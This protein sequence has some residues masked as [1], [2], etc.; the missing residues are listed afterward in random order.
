M[1]TLGNDENNNPVP[2][3][4]EPPSGRTTPITTLAAASKKTI[5]LSDAPESG[6]TVVGPWYRLF[7]PIP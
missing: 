6:K 1:A 3:F 4:A 2:A 5:A 7:I